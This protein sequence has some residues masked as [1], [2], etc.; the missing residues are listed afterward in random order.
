MPNFIRNLQKTV[1]N[2]W[3]NPQHGPR[4][5]QTGP[6]LLDPSNKSSGPTLQSRVLK[7]GQKFQLRKMAHTKRVNFDVIR[8]IVFPAD[9]GPGVLRPSSS[10]TLQSRVLK[11]GQKFQL[12]E[13]AHAKRVNFDVFHPIVLPVDFNPGVLRPSSSHTLQSRVLKHL[14]WAF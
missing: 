14:F 13:M 5:V 10:P 3:G 8:S 12:R 2:P 4:P 9:F 7:Q 1:P 6:G 11:L